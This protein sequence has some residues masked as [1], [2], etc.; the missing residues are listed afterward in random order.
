MRSMP[1]A[2][3]HVFAGVLGWVAVA[4]LVAP[5]V[6]QAH[7]VLKEPPAWMSQTSLGIPEKLG[8]C[9]DESDGTDAATPTNIVTAYQEGQTITVTIDEVIFH[10]GHYRI[11]LAVNDR[12]ELP[13]EPV[14]TVGTSACGSAAI[15]S[16]PVFPV[17]ADGVFV[18]TAAFTTPQ[19]I[20][21]TL[22]A[23]VTCT[24]CTLQVI[25]FMAEHPLNNPGGCFYH[26]CADLSIQA[27][28]D[29]GGV[30]TSSDSGAEGSTAMPDASVGG[31]TAGGTTAAGTSGGG[32]SGGGMSGGGMSGS[33]TSGGG[34][35]GGA[36]SGTGLSGGGMSGGGTGA[37]KTSSSSGCSMVPR[38]PA[39][40]LEW[41]AGLGVVATFALV[42]R[43]RARPSRHA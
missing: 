16:P 5:S 8:P 27:S 31:T 12:S 22:P 25:E 14:V 38:R 20:Q 9:G 32:T 6:A 30:R 29:S 40:A 1:H 15:Q 39:P 43:R 23:N 41:L 13:A 11:A 37:S 2:G 33:G 21:I 26:H 17:L 3:K 18:H 28:S 10:P 7:F 4:L 35:S 19:S 42:R 36:T 24:K 34:T